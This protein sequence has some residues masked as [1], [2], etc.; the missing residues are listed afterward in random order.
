MTAA[1]YLTGLLAGLTLA[2]TFSQTWAQEK[3]LL[4]S[5][6][7]LQKFGSYGVEVIGQNLGV[8]QANLY[9]EDESGRTTR[10]FAVVQFENE[11]SQAVLAIHE[12]ILNGSSIGSTFKEN[13]WEVVKTSQIIEELDLDQLESPVAQSMRLEPPQTLALHIYEF[14]VSNGQDAHI[15]YALIAEL[16]HPVYL[17]LDELH[18]LYQLNDSQMNSDAVNRLKLHIS[19]LL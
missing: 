15:T 8:R 5:E 17:G 14:A 18:D 6:R 1:R 11:M 10:T 9:S 2:L 13:G 3:Q 7:I 12:Q 16:H 4:N 19:E